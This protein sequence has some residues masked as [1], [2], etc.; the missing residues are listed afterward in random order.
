MVVAFQHT[1]HMTLP[2]NNNKSLLNNDRKG[3]RLTKSERDAM[4]MMTM[5]NAPKMQ[6]TCVHWELT[7]ELQWVRPN[8]EEEKKTSIRSLDHAEMY[9]R[10][11]SSPNRVCIHMRSHS[12]YRHIARRIVHIMLYNVHRFPRVDSSMHV[13]DIARKFFNFSE[14]YTRH[15]SKRFVFHS[16]K[17]HCHMKCNVQ[18]YHSQAND[19]YSLVV[20]QLHSKHIP[21]FELLQ[22]TV[23]HYISI[24]IEITANA[25]TRVLYNHNQNSWILS[26]WRILLSQIWVATT[27]Q[28]YNINN[29]NI[30]V[31]CT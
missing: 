28:M 29:L 11:E 26:Y 7:D 19:K 2:L 25:Y 4:I 21:I 27:N 10:W 6:W 1:M 18:K 17:S 12:T 5:K 30:F 16:I 13:D 23:V 8:Y 24:S 15:G 14:F 3:R 9:V 20:Q 31:S 22:W